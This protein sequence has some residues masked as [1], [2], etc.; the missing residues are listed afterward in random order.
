MDLFSGPQRRPRR[1][2]DNEKNVDMPPR[3]GLF[4]EKKSSTQSSNSELEK[5]GDEKGAWSEPRE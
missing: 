4:P 3:K 5:I 1:E 2:D